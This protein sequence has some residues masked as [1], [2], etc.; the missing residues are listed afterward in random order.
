MPGHIYTKLGMWDEGAIWLDAA[1][2]VEKRYM[3][4]RLVLPY[5]AWNYAHNRNFLA[6]AQ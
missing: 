3:Q 2:R 6:N 1:T 5:Q 4:E